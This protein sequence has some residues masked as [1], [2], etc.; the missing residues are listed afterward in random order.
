MYTV[1][2]YKHTCYT[3]TQYLYNKP[4]NAQFPAETPQLK[5]STAVAE[6]TATR[7]KPGRLSLHPFQCCWGGKC[8]APGKKRGSWRWCRSLQTF[9]DTEGKAERPGPV[10][11]SFIGPPL[12]FP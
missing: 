11:N 8:A 1:S 9:V 5:M 2:V 12:P 4:L 6:V 7:C 10:Q 3:P